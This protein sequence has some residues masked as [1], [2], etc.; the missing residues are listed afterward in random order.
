MSDLAF[1]ENE[2]EVPSYDVMF[3]P[4]SVCGTYSSPFES[5]R[6]CLVAISHTNYMDGGNRGYTGE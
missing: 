3:N 6:M 1:C 5:I 2:I 4:F